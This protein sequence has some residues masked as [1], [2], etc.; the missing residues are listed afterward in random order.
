MVCGIDGK[1]YVRG[2]G[3]GVTKTEIRASGPSREIARKEKQQHEM[4]SNEIQIL[5]EEVAT[6][7]QLVQTNTTRSSEQSQEFCN[8][9][10]G[11]ESGLTTKSTRACFLKKLKEKGHSLWTP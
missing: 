11:G 10:R 1:G 2:M 4:V 7:K 9:T 3:G 8:T 5:R 6:L